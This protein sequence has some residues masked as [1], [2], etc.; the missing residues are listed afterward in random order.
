[1]SPKIQNLD[2]FPVSGIAH[3]SF[4]ERYTEHYLVAYIFVV[5]DISVD[6]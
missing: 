3:G 6:G 2:N 4:A 5:E 1:M